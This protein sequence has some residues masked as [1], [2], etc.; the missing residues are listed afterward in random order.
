M[1]LAKVAAE[2]SVA[3][4]TASKVFNGDP[5]VRPYLR[6]RVL[7]AAQRLNYK[8]NILARGLRSKSTSI[9]S[10][11]IQKLENPYFGAMAGTICRLLM[12]EGLVGVLCNNIGRI[13][14]VNRTACACGTILVGGDCRMI[15][16]LAKT[17]LL[18]SISPDENG[19]GIVPEVC[20]G[21]ESAY[22][23]L[24]ENLLAA[25]HTHIGVLCPEESWEVNYNQKFRH[26][27]DA[28]K[29]K[30]GVLA[31]GNSCPFF[32]NESVMEYIESGNRLD[33]V[34]CENDPQA[35]FLSGAIN[36]K[37]SGRYKQPLLVGCDGNMTA[38]GMWSLQI[39]MEELAGASV[40]A[41]RERLQGGNE[42]K[43]ILIKPR[44][45]KSPFLNIES[46]D[47]WEMKK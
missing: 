6:E 43:H 15:K 35:V 3:I 20:I 1:T 41:L 42:N 27:E 13:H 8:P 38:P 12:D 17:T 24:A 23:E 31:G 36:H 46:G 26:L 25:G 19:T 10:L 33:A 30:G 34:C 4:M 9:V 14:E 40:A 37:F 39:D 21:F 16:S 22:T 47:G 44:L 5:S 2:A 11:G 29:R 28:L 18:V 7:E 45:I 32:S